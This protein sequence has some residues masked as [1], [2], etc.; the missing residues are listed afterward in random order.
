M[1]WISECDQ[2]IT[3]L[4]NVDSTE[5]VII[6]VY[7]CNRY[8]ERIRLWQYLVA[9]KGLF[10]SK[11]WMIPGDFNVLMHPSECSK[12]E[13]VPA[14]NLETQEFLDCLNEIEVLDHFSTGCYFTWSNMQENNFQARKLDRLLVNEEWLDA[15]PNSI[16]EF[17]VPGESDH[18][19]DYLQMEKKRNKGS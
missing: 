14:I 13:G 5:F 16:V 9:I 7:A 2:A 3:C 11:P 4:V 1:K 8:I 6:F 17:L 12:F 15:L 19:P 18:S 10:P